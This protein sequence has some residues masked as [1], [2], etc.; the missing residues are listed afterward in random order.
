MRPVAQP[1]RP[2][3]DASLIM[4]LEDA[5]VPSDDRIW[6]AARALGQQDIRCEVILVGGQATEKHTSRLTFRP[7]PLGVAS[8]QEGIRRSRQ[9]M[10]ILVDADTPVDASAWAHLTHA[11]PETA[12]VNC[13]L[14]RQSTRLTRLWMAC[15]RLIVGWLLRTRRHEWARGTTVLRRSQAIHALEFLRD[16]NPQAS[17]TQL[18][19]MIRHHGQFVCET[20]C[21]D[22][23]PPAA[24]VRFR[25]IQ[26]ATSRNLRFWF[27][28]LMFP[29]WQS[30]LSS[31]KPRKRNQRWLTAALLMLAA[32]SLFGNLDY[33]LF[34]P[35]EVRN[36]QLAM[37]VLQSGE[38]F[39]LELQ[40]QPYWNKPPLQTWAIALSYQWFGPTPWATRFPV[41]LFAW[42]TVLI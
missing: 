25:E 20:V 18:L 36:A 12:Q 7:R 34:E 26:K 24:P 38:W 32:V 41:A 40:G 4:V 27:G 28:S 14:R 35:D 17:V 6:E 22:P 1:D 21:Y 37:N 39:A 19:A 10:L 42:L 8:L 11:E 9:P 2:I 30:N 15:Y 5:E 23:G 3:R 29:A 13:T 33:P 16:A 31:A